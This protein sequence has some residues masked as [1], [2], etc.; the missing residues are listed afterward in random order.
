MVS[1]R[2]ESCI[3]REHSGSTAPPIYCTLLDWWTSSSPR[4]ESLAATTAQSSCLPTT[5]LARDHLQGTGQSHLAW[6]RSTVRLKWKELTMRNISCEFSLL[7]KRVKRKPKKW[8]LCPTNCVLK[9][10]YCV[11]NP[12]YAS[13]YEGHVYYIWE[14][15]SETFYY[16]V[17]LCSFPRNG[18]INPANVLYH[19]PNCV[20][21]TCM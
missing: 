10:S 19:V 15:I 6:T 7:P 5:T 13:C 17:I 1:G 2:R 12:G 14:I 3:G 16:V 4:L 8:S 9:Q 18:P 21:W 20:H 11:Q